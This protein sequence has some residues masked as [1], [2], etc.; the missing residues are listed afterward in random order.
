MNNKWLLPL[1]KK[2]DVY[3]SRHLTSSGQIEGHNFANDANNKS[4][5][6]RA[7]NF[8]L[9]RIIAMSMVLLHHFLFHSICKGS[10]PSGIFMLIM[11][12]VA[13]GVNLFFMISGWF[14][15]R[16]SFKSIFILIFTIFSFVLINHL[17]AIPFVE[18]DTFY[19]FYLHI[20]FPISRSPYW[21]IKVYL[22]LIITSP[23]LNR[24]L[25]N[26]TTPML[27]RLILLFILFNVYSCSIGGNQCNSNGFSYMQGVIMYCLGYYLHR[28]TI[29]LSVS[30][31]HWLIAYLILQTIS[32]IGMVFTGIYSIFA[33]YNSILLIAASAALFMFFAQLKF[34][35]KIINYIAGTALGCYLLQDGYFGW[36]FLYGW[37]H[38]IWTSPMSL[39][40]KS[41]IYALIFASFWIVSLIISPIIKKCANLSCS[42]IVRILPP[43]LI[44]FFNFETICSNKSTSC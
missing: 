13:C 1:L 17:V 14:K 35:S 24:G 30:K 11:P 31:Y 8:E 42:Y 25:D 5:N 9:L 3:K 28:D 22:A 44:N 26:L 36:N 10:N 33:L 12:F 7:S 27:R 15:I 6:L 43:R 23:L 16:C 32:G 34:T 29:T 41:L 19:K 18:K 4:T 37:M 2:E 40:L 21:F 39:L 20:A 38:G